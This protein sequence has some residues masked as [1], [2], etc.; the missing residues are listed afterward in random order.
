MQR[1]TFG[2]RIGTAGARTFERLHGLGTVGLPQET[3]FP[4]GAKS[5]PWE[6]ISPYPLNHP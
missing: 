6:G 5:K 3:I 2:A 1:Y 4:L